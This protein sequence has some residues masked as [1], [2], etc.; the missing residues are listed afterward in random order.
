[1]ELKFEQISSSTDEKKLDVSKKEGELA[2]ECRGLPAVDAHCKPAAEVLSGT[3]T[4]RDILDVTREA[5]PAMND[6]V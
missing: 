5:K 2:P 1:M 4:T 6:A 3:A